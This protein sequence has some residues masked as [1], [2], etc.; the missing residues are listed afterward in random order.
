MCHIRHVDHNWFVSWLSA[1]FSRENRYRWHY[2]LNHSSMS[3]QFPS[4]ALLYYGHIFAE[5]IFPLSVHNLFGCDMG[6][7]WFA[8][9]T[10]K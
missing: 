3:H 6:P 2:G 9:R 7:H 10:R 8:R 1:T 5:T 4:R